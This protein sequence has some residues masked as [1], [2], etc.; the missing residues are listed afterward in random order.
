[1]KAFLTLICLFGLFSCK[2]DNDPQINNT[3]KVTSAGMGIDCGLILIDFNVQ[4]KNRIENITNNTNGLRYFAF[5]LDKKFEQVG[6]IL[7]VTLRKTKNDELY[8]CTTQGPAY[9]WVT[10]MTSEIKK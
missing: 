9:P 7:I 4:D 1:M 6:H 10:I 2:K 5:N 8:A 3:F